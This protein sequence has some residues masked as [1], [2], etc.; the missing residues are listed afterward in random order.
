MEH[1]ES[2]QE[3]QVRLRKHCLQQ[4]K[5]RTL[6]FHP[7]PTKP[8]QPRQ[9]PALV[10]HGIGHTIVPRTT[11]SS[12][13]WNLGVTLTGYGCQENSQPVAAALVLESSLSGDL[14][15]ALVEAK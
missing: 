12:P 11:D 10:L 5:A 9:E 7:A 6:S 3:K 8:H 4:A 2:S 15:P 14:T 1:P 13:G